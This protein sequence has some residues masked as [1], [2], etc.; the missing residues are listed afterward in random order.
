[1]TKTKAAALTITKATNQA[2]RH[3]DKILPNTM[4]TVESRGSWD[5]EADVALMVTTITFPGGHPNRALL[6]T[7]L[8]SLAGSVKVELFDTRITLVRTR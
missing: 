3:V 2:R 7:A 5:L 4:S 6:A 1:M 8:H